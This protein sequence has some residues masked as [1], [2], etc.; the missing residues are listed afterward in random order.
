MYLLILFILHCIR[1]FRSFQIEL[2]KYCK[3]KIS[4][5]SIIST[6]SHNFFFSMK[7]KFLDIFIEKKNNNLPKMKLFL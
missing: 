6:I 2:E 3:E 1:N 7:T 4:L 5:V